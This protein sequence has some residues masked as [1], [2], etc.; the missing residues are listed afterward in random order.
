VEIYYFPE[1]YGHFAALLMG[2]EFSFFLAFVADFEKTY[3][4]GSIQS[5]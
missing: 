4:A 5:Q 1:E 3:P 2:G